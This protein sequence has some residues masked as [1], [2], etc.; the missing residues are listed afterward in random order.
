MTHRS[1]LLF[2]IA[3]FLSVGA[4]HAQ[5]PTSL[6]D[7]FERTDDPSLGR[8]PT[9]P[10]D[11]QWNESGQAVGSGSSLSSNETIRINNQ[12]AD[13]QAGQKEGVKIATVDMS[14]VSGYPTTLSDASGV[15]TWAFNFRQSKNDPG[16][17]GSTGNGG[18]AFVLSSAGSDLDDSNALAVVLGDG[19]A[20]DEIKLVN[21]NGGY[22]A[23]GDFSVIATGSDD[24]S[25]EYVSVKV[26]YDPTTSPDTWTLYASS[27]AGSFPTSDP[28]TLDN[29]NEVD[30]AMSDEGTGN[31]RKYIGLLWDHGATSENA[32]FDD[33]YVT[34]PSGRL[35]VELAS[36]TVVTDDRQALLSWTT[37]SETNNA[38]FTVQHK[39]NGTFENVGFVD[40]A[41]TVSQ[42]QDYRF[43]TDALGPGR[44]TFRLQ[45]MDVDGSVSPGPTRTVVVSPTR[46]DL[47]NTGG[48]P[49]TGGTPATFTIATEQAQ[50][51]TATLVNAL[52]QTVR[53]MHERRVSATAD[54]TVETSTLSSGIYFLRA[55]GETFTDTEKFTIVR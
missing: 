38:G 55:E 34:D 53:T 3:L 9:S 30:Q 22:S 15:M 14:N 40:G 31:Q 7:D 54:L 28:R 23:N 29:A 43:A 44:H 51:V 8:T 42:P 26:T 39:V 13:L 48:N 4:A 41:G 1:I 24:L 2:S 35:P 11:I 52:G 37:T 49:V 19:D 50:T 32:V 20:S 36:Y 21:Y 46:S 47:T 18:M 5:L 25:N 45:Q 16:G 10:T 6:L 33:I 27:G 12:R 17:F